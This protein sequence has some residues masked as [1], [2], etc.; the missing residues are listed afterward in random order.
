MDRIM[1]TERYT[2]P[3]SGMDE[4]R[5]MLETFGIEMEAG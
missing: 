2:I 3:A 4:L 5:I 1:A